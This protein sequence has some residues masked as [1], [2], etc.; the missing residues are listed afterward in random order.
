MKREETYAQWIG[1]QAHE[2][3]GGWSEEVWNA[4]WDSA[5]LEAAARLSC[6]VLGELS[7]RGFKWRKSYAITIDNSL[8]ICQR[9]WVDIPPK[10]LNDVLHDLESV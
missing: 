6:K 3:D 8:E 5:L 10:I 9:R 1:S 4:A 7:E 2:N